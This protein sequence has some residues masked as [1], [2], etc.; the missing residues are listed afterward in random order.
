MT[1]WVCLWR[2]WRKEES[3]HKVN[4]RKTSWR[5]E[6]WKEL[7]MWIFVKGGEL[8]I[9]P[10][11]FFGTRTPLLTWKSKIVCNSV[12]G[13]AIL[14]LLG[15]RKNPNICF[16]GTLPPGAWTQNWSW[17][18]KSSKTELPIWG[19]NAKKFK[20]FGIPYAARGGI[21]Q[22]PRSD[23][24]CNGEGR[25]VA[26]TAA[27]GDVPF[28]RAGSPSSSTTFQALFFLHPTNYLAQP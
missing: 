23:C 11:F 15:S 27:S 9:F 7:H 24:S 25:C 1:G 12:D 8:K 26:V 14:F 22:G 5:G 28:T 13:K 2:G 3:Y 20:L 6:L 17:P 10:F 19:A 21:I 18:N 16:P 4:Q